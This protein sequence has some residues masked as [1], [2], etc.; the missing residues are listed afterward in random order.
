MIS[1]FGDLLAAQA[2]GDV[3][4]DREVLEER[5]A[6]EDRVDV[7][8]VGRHALD[9]LPL[10]Q[11]V[12]LVGL[13]EPGDH[14]QC[15]RL[16]AARRAEHREEGSLRDV[17]VEVLDGVLVAEALDHPAQRDGELGVAHSA[18]GAPTAGGSVRRRH[19]SNGSVARARKRVIA[20]IV[21]PTALISGETPTRS[22]E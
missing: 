15:R 12:A 1:G 16:A 9:R 3:V 14:P 11:D 20:I 22:R 21:V 10:E 17:E 18:A 19:N 8:P 7:A 5:V 6:L 2:E 13:L 4:L